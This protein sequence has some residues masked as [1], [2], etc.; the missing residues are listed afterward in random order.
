MSALD[1]LPFR[2]PVPG[3]DVVELGG[4]ESVSYRLEGLLHL[5]EQ[6]VSLEWTGTRKTEYVGL[7]GV[8][9]E[10]DH[11]PV[12]WIEI[13]VAWITEVRV[14]GGW[15]RP[16]FELRARRLD[17]FEGV[18]AARAGTLSVKIA[19]RD[20]GLAADMAAAI[21]M[22]RADLALAEAERAAALDPGEE[23]WLERG[24]D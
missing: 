10:H 21:E 9:T 17:A 16:R 11:L 7:T 19:R 20:R 5:K 4:I 23:R 1:P 8:G 18:P 6:L 3:A 15:W 14:R 22:A 12:E 2:L 24:G 13:P